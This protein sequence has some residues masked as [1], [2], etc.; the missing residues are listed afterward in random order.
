[1]AKRRRFQRAVGKRR[2]RK[3]VVIAMEGSKTEP[4]YFSLFDDRGS[5]IKP[6]CLKACHDSA[7]FYVLKRMKS[8]L[9]DTGLKSTDEAWLVVD[10]DKW[11]EEQLDQL[12]QWSEQQDNYGFAL[13]NPKFEYWLLLHFE[14]GRGVGSARECSE[15]LKRYMPNYH[16]DVNPRTFTSVRIETAMGRASRR[17][18][19]PCE[20]WP[21][22][23]AK[24]T[25]YRLVRV[26]LAR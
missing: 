17:D 9:K 24:T 14:D 20:D 13:S 12:Y 23:F 26:L 1:M 6:L 8:Y 11:T 21:K 10:R 4:Q 5:T 3:L 18:N 16:K 15:R 25:V 2:Y 7:P 19:P 22:E